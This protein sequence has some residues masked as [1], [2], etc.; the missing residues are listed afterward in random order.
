MTIDTA[1]TTATTTDTAEWAALIDLAITTDSRMEPATGV[2]GTASVRH[3][4]GISGTLIAASMDGSPTGTNTG[5]PIAPAIRRVIGAD[6]IRADGGGKARFKTWHS[7]KTEE[8]ER[9]SSVFASSPLYFGAMNRR[10]DILPGS[11]EPST[12][13]F[14]DWIF[15]GQIPCAN[16]ALF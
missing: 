15:C 2:R 5:K 11:V 4:A 9:R 14:G 16:T 3:T 7:A 13:D 12:V 6:T 10:A 8:R 1:V